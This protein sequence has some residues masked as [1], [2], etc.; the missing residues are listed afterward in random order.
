MNVVPCALFKKKKCNIF[1]FT[2]QPVYGDSWSTRSVAYIEECL[3]RTIN[4]KT[5]LIYNY[6]NLV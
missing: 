3:T 2:E 6:V 1:Y 5:Q 4:S